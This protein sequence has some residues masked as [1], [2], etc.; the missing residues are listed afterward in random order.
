[1]LDLSERYNKLA[2][3]V[4]CPT[5]DKKFV[6]RTSY[7][8]VSCNRCGSSFN[9][10][11]QQNLYH[12]YIGKVLSTIGHEGG[13]IIKNIPEKFYGDILYFEKVFK[14]Q[15]SY[16]VSE[17]TKKTETLRRCLKCGICNN[18]LTCKS[19]TKTFEKNQNR[20]K[21]VCPDCGSNET[22]PTYFKEA[23]I[24]TDN[25]ELK[26]CPHC[27]SPNIVL[28]LSNTKSKCH[29]CGSKQLSEPKTDNIYSITIKKKQGYI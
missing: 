9:T 13:I 11:F 3:E 14:M 19:C 24:P 17:I 27:H 21:Q 7:V 18:C 20:R 8:K 6:T 25:K 2:V 23:F 28:T 4:K 15:K 1:M 5:C 26:Q 10:D 29:L 16:D 22:I 12:K